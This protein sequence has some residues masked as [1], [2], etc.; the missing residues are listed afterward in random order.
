MPLKNVSFSEFGFTQRHKG[1]QGTKGRI[2]PQGCRIY[3]PTL[4]CLLT[5]FVVSQHFTKAA[6]KKN[7]KGGEITCEK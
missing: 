7:M 1:N 6:N 3:T 4:Q 2:Q 5:R